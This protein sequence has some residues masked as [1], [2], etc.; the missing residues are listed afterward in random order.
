MSVMSQ[1]DYVLKPGDKVIRRPSSSELSPIATHIEHRRVPIRGATSPM[2]LVYSFFA[3]AVVGAL[4]LS[5]PAMNSTHHFLSPIE[6]FFTSVSA[7]TGTGLVVSDT[8]EAFTGLGQAVIAGLI[9]VGGLGFMTGAAA[10]LFLMGRRSSMQARLVIGAGLDDSRLGRVATLAKGIILMAVLVQLAGAVFLFVRW[11]L[12]GPAWEGLSVGEAIWQSIFTSVSSFNN[13]GFDIIPDELAGGSSL[14][15]FAN[16]IPTLL[17]IGVLILAGSTSYAVLA[18]VTRVR[19]WRKLTLD[20]KLVLLGIGLML[21]IGFLAFLISEWNNPRT[22]GDE[23]LAGKLTQSTFHSVNRTSGFSTVDYGQLDSANTSVTT[24]LMFVGGVSASTAAGIKVNTLMV[25]GVATY[26][27]LGGRQRAKIFGREI[28]RINVMRAF[29]VG[30]AG[31]AAVLILVIALFTVQ[32]E[33]EYKMAVFEIISA[34]G[35][36]GW[37]AG[38]TSSLNDAALT[39]VSMTMF[40]GRFG[41]LTIA[42]FMAGRERESLVKYPQERVRIG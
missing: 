34:F 8:R 26:A 42:L 24:G 27:M 25:I 15:G 37:S 33:L 10:L 1:K 17:I 11:Y 20:T 31:A 23:T 14:T 35:T 36:V 12:V 16:D 9:F 6:T 3:V 4:L 2:V 7:M 32:P 19:G 5:M 30:A 22:I 38:I 41:P 29:T 21:L 40:V 39:V 13:A 28:P 18:N